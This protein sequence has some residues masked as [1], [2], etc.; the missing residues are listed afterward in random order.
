MSSFHFLAFTFS[1]ESYHPFFSYRTHCSLNSVS[2]HIPRL[3]PSRSRS[4][5]PLA[6]QLFPAWSLLSVI[7]APTFLPPGKVA[8]AGTNFPSGRK[9]RLTHDNGSRRWLSGKKYRLSGLKTSDLGNHMN[10]WKTS[11]TINSAQSRKLCW[12]SFKWLV[13]REK[14][15]WAEKRSRHPRLWIFSSSPTPCFVSMSDV[16][17]AASSSHFHCFEFFT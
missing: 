11:A 3:W 1:L 7:F 4:R 13:I 8:D 5:A 10:G 2:N 16:S 17:W 14:S 6:S 15:W 9:R 12:K